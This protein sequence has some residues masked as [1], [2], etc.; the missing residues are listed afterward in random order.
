MAEKTQNAPLKK[1]SQSKYI[2]LII[3]GTEVFLGGRWLIGLTNNPQRPI[4]YI[5]WGVTNLLQNAHF[6]RKNNK[7]PPQKRGQC[8]YYV[9]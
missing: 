1:R 5:F 2:N 6:L 8:Y 3:E 9:L 7:K 4:Y